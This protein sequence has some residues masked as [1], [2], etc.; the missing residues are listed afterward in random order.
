MK[1]KS[2]QLPKHEKSGFPKHGK[3]MGKHKHFKFMGSLN[4][5]GEGEILTIPKILE[6]QIFVVREKYGKTQ[7]FPIVFATSQI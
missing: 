5:S 3:S 2:I 6:K 4:I 7:R 1:Q